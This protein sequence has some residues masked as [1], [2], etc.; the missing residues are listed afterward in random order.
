MAVNESLPVVNDLGGAL[1]RIGYITDRPPVNLTADNDLDLYETALTIQ[2]STLH[3]W[4][5][6]SKTK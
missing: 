2:R 3:Q 5:N 4:R 6:P 1:M